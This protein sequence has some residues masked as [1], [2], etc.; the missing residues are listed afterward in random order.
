MNDRSTPPIPPSLSVWPTGQRDPLAQLRDAGCVPGTETD[1]ERI[2]PAVAA[3]AIAAFSRHG[4]L[5][6][7]PDC[8]A[9]T[10]LAAALHAGRHT[11]GL[12]AR[13]RW[14]KTA[15]ANVTA[16]K[17]AGSPCEGSVVDARPTM[18]GTARAAGLIGRTGLVLTILRTTPRR[19]VGP[20]RDPVETALADL[21]ET[22]HYCES[23]LRPGGRVV[24]LARP[25][26]HRN[27]ALVDLTTPI[28]AAA[29]AARLEPIERCIALTAELRGSR[30]LTHASLRQRRAVA[31]ADVAGAPAAIP[32]HIEALV[33]RNA[34][35]TERDAAAAAASTS[36]RRAIRAVV[37]LSDSD[38]L[39]TA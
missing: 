21:A 31:R 19:A 23:L 26:R 34:D 17:A 22:L 29:I 28:V 38:L 2:P 4:D 5:V 1:A 11:L 3:H 39:Q 24:V 13:S 32:A 35:D 14:W 8:G 20:D 37:E 16:A 25:R 7:D 12:T 36:K 27:G 30:L 33:F 15:R 9:G 6:V 10:V 18:L